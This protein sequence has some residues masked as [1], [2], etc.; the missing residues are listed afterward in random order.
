M[1]FKSA[2]LAISSLKVS[3]LTFVANSALTS[4][5]FVSK[6]ALLAFLSTSV[7]KCSKAVLLAIP[8]IVTASSVLTVPVPSTLSNVTLPSL[9]TA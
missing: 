3:S 7:F 9:F 6:S 4:P 2:F 8:V 5:I 1:A